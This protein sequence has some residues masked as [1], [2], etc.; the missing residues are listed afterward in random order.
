MVT[1]LAK[2]DGISNIEAGRRL[3][4]EY[5]VKSGNR[6][7][8]AVWN[9]VKKWEPKEPMPTIELPP[10]TRLDECRGFSAAAIAH[11][12]L[13]RVPTGILIP[14]RDS[15]RIV[16]YAIR[17]TDRQ[18]KYLNSEG[19][20]KSDLLYGFAENEQDIIGAPMAAIVCEGQFDCI[21]VWDAGYKNVVATM[22]S[23]MSPSQA[24]ILASWC[25]RVTILYDGDDTGRKGAQRIQEMYSS[26]FNIKIISLAEGEDPDVAD[27]SILKT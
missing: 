10:S 18:P 2:L 11:F 27:L 1:L 14:F 19:F 24:H 15:S 7:G 13:R 3:V 26:I 6:S 25:S 4:A 8:D 5:G 23:S 22:G 20:R 17:Q 9:E 21:R 16:G 12:G